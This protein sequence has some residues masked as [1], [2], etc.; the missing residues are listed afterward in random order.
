MVKKY[1][2]MMLVI[3][4]ISTLLS[5]AEE[6]KA[7]PN[8]LFYVAN[9]LYEKKDYA[10]AADEYLKIVD[11]GLE[12]GSLYY[13][14]GNSF[15]KMGKIGYAILSYEKAKTFIPRDSDLKSNLAY[16]R[17]LT[18]DAG[19]IQ[20]SP[21][22]FIINII[23]RPF[24][25]FNLNAIAVSA[26]ILYLVAIVILAAFLLKPHFKARSGIL[27]PIFFSLF[28]LNL[29]AFGVRYYDEHIL[30]HGVVIQK[31]V[32]CKYEPIEKSMIYYKI[33][34]GQD[35]LILDTRNGWRQIKRPDGKI[36]WVAK[37]S[38]EEIYSKI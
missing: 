26:A 38:V 28:L 7:D 2:F 22:N 14:I 1:F 3:L 34:E 13:N 15:L 4:F 8:Q 24:R 21:K 9:G 10:K 29:A 5:Y 11:L 19:I 6:K 33:H 20:E 16:A 25:D 36:G 30:E 32:E 37:E 12:S 27:F 17:S 23:K 35:V 31:E 18:G